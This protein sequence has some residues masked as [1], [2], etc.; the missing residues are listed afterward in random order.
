MFIR[1]LDEAG[2]P[3]GYSEMKSLLEFLYLQKI[4][5]LRKHTPEEGLYLHKSKTRHAHSILITPDSKQIIELLHH[6][7]DAPLGLAG[8]KIILGQGIETTIREGRDI[9]TGQ[10]V[11]IKVYPLYKKKSAPLSFFPDSIKDAIAKWKLTQ[12][13]NQRFPDTFVNLHSYLLAGDK[14][15]DKN[16]GNILLYVIMDKHPMTLSA[17]MKNKQVSQEDIKNILIKL[18]IKYRKLMVTGYIYKDAHAGN[19]LINND[20][21]PVL[22]DPDS[23]TTLIDTSEFTRKAS[24]MLT[25]YFGSQFTHSDP[26]RYYKICDDISRFIHHFYQEETPESYIAETLNDL[27]AGIAFK[28]ESKTIPDLKTQTE[29]ATLPIETDQYYLMD[30]EGNLPVAGYHRK[31]K[32]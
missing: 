30:E 15:T 4:L 17:M 12:K 6:D 1:K 19:V 14:S 7:K 2:R 18:F 10:S 20:K 13:I 5:P 27:F 29:S 25:T 24:S 8:K 23:L 22:C 11:A 26:D 21:E 32:R 28:K 16:P 9:T 3:S 31:S